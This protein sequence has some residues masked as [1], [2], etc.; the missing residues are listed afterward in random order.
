MATQENHEPKETESEQGDEQGVSRGRIMV[1][2]AL[3]VVEQACRACCNSIITEFRPRSGRRSALRRGRRERLRASAQSPYSSIGGVSLAALGVAFLRGADFI[4]LPVSPGFQGG[5]AGGR[6]AAA[7]PSR[8]A[9]GVDIVL[10]GLQAF[11]I[12]AYCKLCIATYGIN[13]AA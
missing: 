5:S 6:R 13:G 9:V 3:L 1:L 11:G 4:G 10:L 8:A 2:I 12:G 7:L